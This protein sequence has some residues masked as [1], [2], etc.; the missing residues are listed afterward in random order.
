[1]FHIIDSILAVVSLPESFEHVLQLKYLRITNYTC[2]GN[3][4]ISSI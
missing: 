3:P 2:D 4:V 1:M